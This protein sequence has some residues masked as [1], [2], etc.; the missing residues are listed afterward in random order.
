METIQIVLD[1]SLLQAT[2]RAARRTKQNRSALIREAL[3]EHLRRLE[4]RAKEELD[5]AGYLKHP[6]MPEDAALWEGD[7]AWP[8]E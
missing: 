7:A 1:K 4:G 2:D 8:P 6:P 5:R 3:H